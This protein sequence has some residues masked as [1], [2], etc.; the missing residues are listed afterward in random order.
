M[1]TIAKIRY[2]TP[3][4]QEPVLVVEIGYGREF[5][6]RI[7]GYVGEKIGRE[8]GRQIDNNFADPAN[9]HK[10]YH[11]VILDDTELNRLERLTKAD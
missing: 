1:K 7:R 2:A 4:R 8:L 11:V 6:T 5:Q 10:K 3:A 9:R